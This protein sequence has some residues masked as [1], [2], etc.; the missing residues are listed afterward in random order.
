VSSVQC[1]CSCSCFS[2]SRGV[3]WSGG[4]LCRHWRL[5][6]SKGAKENIKAEKLPESAGWSRRWKGREHRAWEPAAQ[7][8]N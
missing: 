4:S 1:S 3:V 7:Q 8:K 5:S 6:Y 2:P